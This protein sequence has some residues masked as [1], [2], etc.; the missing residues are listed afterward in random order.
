MTV[1]ILV[2]FIFIVLC[3]T[4]YIIRQG[5]IKAK[6]TE[7]FALLRLQVGCATKHI[8]WLRNNLFLHHCDPPSLIFLTFLSPTGY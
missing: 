1:V 6:T 7:Y 3:G 8:N 4:Y 2:L 5:D